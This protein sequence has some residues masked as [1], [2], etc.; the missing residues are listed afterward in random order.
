MAVVVSHCMRRRPSPWRRCSAATASRFRCAASSPK[1]MMA[2]AA[3]RNSRRATTTDDS[4][5]DMKCCTRAGVHDQVRPCSM[6]SRDIS[7]ISRAS[8]ARANPMKASSDTLPPEFRAPTEDHGL[9]PTLAQI[10]CRRRAGLAA[11]VSIGCKHELVSVARLEC[12]MAGIRHD[13]QVRFG[14]RAVQVPGAGRGAYDIVAPLNDGRGNMPNPRH[15]VDQ[16]ALAAQETAIHEVMALD[17]RNRQR[18]LIFAPF[19]DVF[20]IAVQKTGRGLPRRPCPRC[21]QRRA[22]IGTGETL[23]VSAQKIIALVVRNRVAIRFPI[24]RKYFRGTVLIKPAYFSIAQQENTAQHDFTHP[25]RVSLRIR[26]RQRAAPGSAE[27][28]PALYAQMLAQAFD[29]GDQVPCR[30][31]HQAGARPAA[32]AAALIE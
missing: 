25:L 11:A 10:P 15:I 31:F 6:R 24:I 22:L 9:Y 27:Y 2:N 12:R 8:L 14:P 23:V 30:I 1:C 17:S 16:L 18:K 26:Q 32:P 3:I 20:D 7:A 19:P 28:Q 5:P 29:V 4:A 21:C 13:A